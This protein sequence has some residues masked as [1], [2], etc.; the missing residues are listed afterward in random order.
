MST[1][2]A[3]ESSLSGRSAVGRATVG[4]LKMT[5]A[6]P[7]ASR[8]VDFL[9]GKDTEDPNSLFQFSFWRCPSD[10]STF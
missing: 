6:D 1:S 5:A 9:R 10:V 3:T 4:L 2:S 8:G 7:S